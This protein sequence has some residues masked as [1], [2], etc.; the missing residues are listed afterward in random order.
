MEKKYVGFPNHLAGLIII[1]KSQD[2]VLYY[3]QDFCISATISH[4]PR[5]TKELIILLVPVYN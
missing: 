5:K 1:M 3:G 2:I 4:T